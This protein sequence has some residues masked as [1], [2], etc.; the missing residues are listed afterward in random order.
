MKPRLQTTFKKFLKE[1][2]HNISENS[3]NQYRLIVF[4]QQLFVCPSL[5]HFSVRNSSLSSTRGAGYSSY[6]VH[7]YMI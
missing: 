4:F 2:C 7:I 6:Y 1:T 5:E 3:K